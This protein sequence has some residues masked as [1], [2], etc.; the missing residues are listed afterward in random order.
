MRVGPLRLV[1]SVAKAI[2]HFGSPLLH[3]RR[4]HL[5]QSS[6]FDHHACTPSCGSFDK[7]LWGPLQV[8]GS[9]EAC[10]EESPFCLLI[11]TKKDPSCIHTSVSFISRRCGIKHST[12]CS[13]PKTQDICTQDS[14]PMRPITYHDLGMLSCVPMWMVSYVPSWV[15]CDQGDCCERWFWRLLRQH[16]QLQLTQSCSSHSLASSCF[17]HCAYTPTSSRTRRWRKVHWIGS[18][19]PRFFWFPRES[20]SS[21]L[22]IWLLLAIR[23]GRPRQKA[24]SCSSCS[25]CPQ[26]C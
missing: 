24:S 8:H 9:G 21:T 23:I 16:C 22:P 10:A 13:M 17:S 12:M 1:D 26:L 19:W 11:F 6:P 20:S 5:D 18:I 14:R 4:H 15:T 2:L 3:Y 7:A 25:F